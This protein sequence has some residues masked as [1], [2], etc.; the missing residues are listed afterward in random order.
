VSDWL[1]QSFAGH[2]DF[3]G[4]SMVYQGFSDKSDIKL[5]VLHDRTWPRLV[6]VKPKYNDTGWES[7][8]GTKGPFNNCNA[9]LKVRYGFRADWRD[10]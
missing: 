8:V 3:S 7:A 6:A 4:I 9:V 1:T 10:V 5:A 2:S